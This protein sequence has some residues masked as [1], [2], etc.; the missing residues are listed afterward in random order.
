MRTRGLQAFFASLTHELRTPLTSI[1]LQAESI[2]DG[3]TESAQEKIFVQRLLEDTQKLEQ[4][5]ER[6]LELARVEGG[7]PLFTQ[8]IDLLSSI[9]RSV[10]EW[11]S[12]QGKGVSVDLRVSD[13][14]I[15]ADP[16][17]IQVILKNLLENAVR[18]AREKLLVIAIESRASD[19][20]VQVV[21]R[22]NGKGFDGNPKFLGNLFE[23]GAHS[24]GAGVGLYLIQVMMKRM[25]G[26]ARFG[27]RD[28]GKSGF[29]AR[30]NFK[31]GGSNGSFQR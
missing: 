8:K 1:R 4:Q 25:G 2:A 9:E 29:E 6:I 3:M 30:L 22:D 11:K 7:G 16:V 17:A 31:A 13:A 20:G 10:R 15:E 18:H 21:F 23:K 5:V 26:S 24:Q 19:D 12:G 27:A 28:D 14:V